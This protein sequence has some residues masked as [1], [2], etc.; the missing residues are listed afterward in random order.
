MALIHAS[1]CM[2]FL[3]TLVQLQVIHYRQAPQEALMLGA[4]LN[5]LLLKITTHWYSVGL[6][7]E[8]ILL[9]VLIY[10]ILASSGIDNLQR[11]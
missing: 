7:L 4:R 2:C 11:T 8:T 5:T 10:L 9:L 6:V 3:S 1:G